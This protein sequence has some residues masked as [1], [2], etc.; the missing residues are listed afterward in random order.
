V[1]E[2]RA[3]A[4]DYGFVP[5]RPALD[6]DIETVKED[7]RTPISIVDG[8]PRSSEDFWAAVRLT[9]SKNRPAVDVSTPPAGPSSSGKRQRAEDESDTEEQTAD[10][11]PSKRARLCAAES[12]SS[13]TFC[14]LTSG[15]RRRADNENEIEEDVNGSPSKRTRLVEAESADSTNHILTLEKR[16][17]VDNEE[18]DGRDGSPSRCAPIGMT[19]SGSTRAHAFSYVTSPLRSLGRKAGY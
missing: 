14:T 7:D 17:R 1:L 8:I 19:I 11:T 6:D 5:P 16:R 18:E 4:P 2:Y 15:K 12:V 3:S 13:T 10:N 9:W